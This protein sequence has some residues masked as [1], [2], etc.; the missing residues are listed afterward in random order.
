MRLKV[1]WFF[2]FSLMFIM[3]LFPTFVFAIDCTMDAQCPKGNV[4]SSAGFCVFSCKANA[5]CPSGQECYNGTCVRSGSSTTYEKKA[6]A[7][8]DDCEEGRKCLSGVCVLDTVAT[9]TDDNDKSDSGVEVT[10]GGRKFNCVRGGW[11]SGVSNACFCCGQCE[12]RDLLTVGN[13]FL[14]WLFGIVGAIGLA[15]FVWGGFNWITSAGDPGKITT[16]KKAITNTMVGLLIMFSAGVVVM[17]IQKTLGLDVQISVVGQLDSNTG[18]DATGS[19]DA[20]QEVHGNLQLGDKCTVQEKTSNSDCAKDLYCY[21][22]KDNPETKGI[23]LPKNPK[24]SSKPG[25]RCWILNDGNTCSLGECLVLVEPSVDPGTTNKAIPGTEGVC[26]SEEDVNKIIGKAC[27]ADTECGSGFKCTNGKCIIVTSSNMNRREPCYVLPGS[28]TNDCIS[29]FKCFPDL[30]NATAKRTVGTKGTCA[31]NQS[32]VEGKIC[33]GNV[34]CKTGLL[35]KRIPKAST[36]VCVSKTRKFDVPVGGSCFKFTMEGSSDPDDQW[37]NVIDNC[38]LGLD[39]YYGKDSDKSG[40]CAP[41][42]PVN[43]VSSIGGE[44]YILPGSSSMCANNSQCVAYISKAYKTTPGS[45]GICIPKYNS[46]DEGQTC[47]YLPG[48]KTVCK[49][50]LT[51]DIG[52]W[53]KEF[54]R[55]GVCVRK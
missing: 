49:S 44:C 52:M 32:L 6:C 31:Y 34:E 35:C 28:N 42:N 2:V 19:T 46:V 8:N 41:P 50:G 5:D 10:C 9:D 23:C 51:C 11:F 20:S 40:I 43:S 27:K 45:K 14:K 3:F 54:G 36:E 38:V 16:G 18:A 30:N 25:Y 37:K 29:D 4:C 17:T 26:T 12:P 33:I 13:T 22:V 39:C 24:G 55:Q 21:A 15:M 53:T 48:T 7:K 47:V 1:K